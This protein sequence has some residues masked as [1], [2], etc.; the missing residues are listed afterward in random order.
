MAT[1]TKE[2]ILEEA[3]RLYSIVDPEHTPEPAELE[4]GGF[5]YQAQQSLM[6][7]AESARAEEQKAKAKQRREEHKRVE[8]AIRA[9]RHEELKPSEE[10]EERR[11]AEAVAGSRMEIVKVKGLNCTQ[12]G[13]SV[14][15]CDELRVLK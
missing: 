13:H 2:E 12:K 10:G 7:S 11:I 8:E 3:K 6:R 1:P 5:I 15:A 4:E 9:S 14:Y